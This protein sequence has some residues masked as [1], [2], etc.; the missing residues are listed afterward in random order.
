MV[1]SDSKYIFGRCGWERSGSVSPVSSFP[2]VIF[3]LSPVITS[4]F[5]ELI[6]VAHCPA[7]CTVGIFQVI[8][9]LC[10][11]IGSYMFHRAR[12]QN[13]FICCHRSIMSAR[14]Y[15]VQP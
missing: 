8:F 3:L 13:L 6:V 14:M 11:N 4:R 12:V 1:V 7:R 15:P 2:N 9:I 5:V 10:N